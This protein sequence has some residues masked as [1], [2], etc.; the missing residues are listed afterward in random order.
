M[1]HIM[2]ELS[3]G[4]DERNLALCTCTTVTILRVEELDIPTRH[5]P[6]SDL[7][8]SQR[9]LIFN[10]TRRTEYQKTG[11]RRIHERWTS[12]SFS[13]AKQELRSRIRPNKRDWVFSGVS[14]IFGNRYLVASFH[15]FTNSQ[16]FAFSL[17]HS[18]P[19]ILKVHIW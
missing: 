1:H 5:H 15:G 16:I 11:I 14:N 13:L 18:T 3:L 12:I 10:Q 2:K 7:L 9:C 19:T 17:L 4:W 8:P 6:S